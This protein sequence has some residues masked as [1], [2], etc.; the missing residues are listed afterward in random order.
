MVRLVA[1][2]RATLYKTQQTLKTLQKHHS[3]RERNKGAKFIKQFKGDNQTTVENIVSSCSQP[4]G[5]SLQSKLNEE[6]KTMYRLILPRP[7][8]AENNK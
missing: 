8:H 4:I 1:L 5:R 2:L 6:N 3:I 7:E